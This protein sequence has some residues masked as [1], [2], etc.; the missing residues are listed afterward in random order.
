[1]MYTRSKPILSWKIIVVIE[2]TIFENSFSGFDNEA[3]EER[4]YNII[5]FLKFD[6]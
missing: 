4:N 6:D 1:M 5:L 3:D 2:V